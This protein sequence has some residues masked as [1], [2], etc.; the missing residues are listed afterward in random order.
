MLVNVE[1][2]S[3]EKSVDVTL[4]LKHP[5]SFKIYKNGE[6]FVESFVGA[7]TITLGVGEGIF[8]MEK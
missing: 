2:T 1:D 6:C 4:T 3:K 7:F 8:M 5:A